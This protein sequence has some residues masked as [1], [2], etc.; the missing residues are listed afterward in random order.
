[1]HR[2][3]VGRMGIIP[4]VTQIKLE[5]KCTE[6]SHKQFGVIGV[7]LYVKRRLDVLYAQHLIS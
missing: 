4:K 5:S 1:M 3:F 2:I 7:G 6:V